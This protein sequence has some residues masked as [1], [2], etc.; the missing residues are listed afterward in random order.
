MGG[1]RRGIGA[2]SG[3]FEDRNVDFDKTGVQEVLASG[4]PVAAAANEAFFDFGVHS[5]I[6]I[7]AAEAFFFVS[8]AVAAGEGA[9]RFGKKG[10]F[11]GAF[12]VYGY[13]RSE[14]DNLKVG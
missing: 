4:L 2:T 9:E 14:D 1:E 13:L 12:S 7:A 3:G 8:E 6:E 10:D 11:I 5:D